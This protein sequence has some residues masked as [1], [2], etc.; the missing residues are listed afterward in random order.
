MGLRVQCT[1]ATRHDSIHGYF[2]LCLLSEKE[3]IYDDEEVDSYEWYCRMTL[4]SM[5]VF[6]DRMRTYFA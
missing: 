4:G 5:F 2:G 6:Y 1:T 3:F